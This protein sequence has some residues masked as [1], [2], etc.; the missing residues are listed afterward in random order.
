MFLTGIFYILY[1]YKNYQEKR[2]YIF[3][4]YKENI[5][6]RQINDNNILILY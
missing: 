2:I 4:L 6:S 5:Y 3:V 1:V